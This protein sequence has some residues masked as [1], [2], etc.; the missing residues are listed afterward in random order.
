M[1]YLRLDSIIAGAQ[2]AMVVC[3]QPWT[4][5]KVHIFHGEPYTT[6]VNYMV[7]PSSKLVE[8]L[9]LLGQSHTS[10][11][12][13]SEPWAVTMSLP[14]LW[15]LQPYHRSFHNHLMVGFNI[16]RYVH[17][18]LTVSFTIY[19]YFRTCLMVVHSCLMVDVN[20][21]K[22]THIHLMVHTLIP[23][24]MMVGVNIPRW[25]GHALW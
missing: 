8:L 25:N 11:V 16:P 12:M 9:W 17:S 22:Y 19:K 10:T 4:L 18:C 5:W 7:A 24:Y 15:P 14:I 21:P 23:T 1:T 20:I 3:V 6:T 2:Q 13:L